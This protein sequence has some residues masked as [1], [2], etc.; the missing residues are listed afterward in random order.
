MDELRDALRQTQEGLPAWLAEMRRRLDELAARL[1]AEV[2][3]VSA[4]LEGLARRVDE[5]LAR[6]AAPPVPEETARAVP[7]AQQAVDYLDHRQGGGLSGPCPLPELFAAVRGAGG[8]LGLGDFHAGLRRL[9]DRG[10]VRLLPPDDR[11]PI[12]EPEYA[13]LDGAA[14]YYYVTRRNGASAPAER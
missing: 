1:T 12:A 3:T 13:L 10:V 4:R 9:S 14:T 8:E 6:T 2:Q 7:W 11:G 5:A